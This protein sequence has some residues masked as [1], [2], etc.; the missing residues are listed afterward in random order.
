MLRGDEAGEPSASED[1]RPS[2]ALAVI[3]AAAGS[4]PV[5]GAVL[6]AAAH[7]AQ[8]VTDDADIDEHAALIAALAALEAPHF[9]YLAR[10]ANATV[11]DYVR[12][13]Q[14]PQPYRAALL[15]TGVLEEPPGPGV[16][17]FNIY[18]MTPFGQELLAWI[19]EADPSVAAE[20]GA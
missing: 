13:G 2:V 16:T 7:L 4:V 8:A 6:V 14:I 5:L 12:E 15:S 11:A 18:K 19:V 1:K 9:R 17:R 20:P 10:F 3:E